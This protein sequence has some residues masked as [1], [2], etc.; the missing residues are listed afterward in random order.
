MKILLD[1]HYLIW[2]FTAP[3]KI[4]SR[5]KRQ[6]QNEENEIYYSQINLWEISIK[7][8]LG[9]L[10]LDGGDPETLCEEIEGSFL[11]C[12]R[13]EN[14]ELATFHKCPK[15]HKDPFDRFLIWQ[16][17]LTEMHFLSQDGPIEGYRK[18]G[19]KLLKDTV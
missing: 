3:E 6:L 17:I 10:K 1:T 19:L 9:K 5:F 8:H 14:K 18:F 4:E 7:Y 12:K 13:L 2:L 11:L 16:S 15:L